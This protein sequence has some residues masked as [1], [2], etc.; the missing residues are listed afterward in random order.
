M[1]IVKKIK[2]SSDVYNPVKFLMTVL[3]SA[4]IPID[5]RSFKRLSKIVGEV[6][7][8]NKSDA[9]FREEDTLFDT[10]CRLSKE[11]NFYIVYEKGVV[12]AYKRLPLRFKIL[13]K[14]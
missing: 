1:A 14:E 7:F 11:N 6:K 9:P 2:R 3:K 5:T 13:K 4:D 12:K 10:I 8:K